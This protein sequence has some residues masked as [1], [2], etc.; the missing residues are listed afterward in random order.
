M[1]QARQRQVISLQITLNMA[2]PHVGAAVEAL[3]GKGFFFGGL[4]P[5]WFGTDGLLMQQ[6]W[7]VEPHYGGIKLYTPL[8]KELLAYIKTDRQGVQEK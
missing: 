2:L 4:A 5:L 6:L 7:G 1:A 8:A 3:C